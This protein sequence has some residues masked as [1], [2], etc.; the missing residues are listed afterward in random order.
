MFRRTTPAECLTC[1][2]QLWQR[3]CERGC[4]WYACQACGRV[5]DPRRGRTFRR[6]GEDEEETRS[7]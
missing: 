6:G 1:N 7:A 4:G 2:Q 3:H 5:I